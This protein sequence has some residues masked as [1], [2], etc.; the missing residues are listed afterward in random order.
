M[1]GAGGE[2]QLRSRLAAH[3]AVDAARRYGSLSLPAREI[4]TQGITAAL[5]HISEGVVVTLDCDSFDPSIMP[6]VAERTLGGS[7]VHKQST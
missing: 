7:P 2:G 6:R 5:R 4:P 3:A 1:N